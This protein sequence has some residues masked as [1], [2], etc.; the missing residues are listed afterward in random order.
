M[1]QEA[2][3]KI[4]KSIFPIFFHQKLN[5]GFRIGV[6]GTGFFIEGDLFVTA[7]HVINGLPKESKALYFGNV[8]DRPLKNPI[9][10]EEVYSDEVKDIFIG[11]VKAQSLDPLELSEAI[12]NA[13]KSICLSGYPLANL[14]KAPD[15]TINVGNVRPYWQP[16]FMVDR[17]TAN[18]ENRNY[19]GFMTQHTSL[20][21]MSGG[22]VFDT[23]GIVF[24]VDVATLTRKI[25]QTDG[26]EQLVPNG[27]VVGV[28]TLH[29]VLDTL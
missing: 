19:Q 27:V 21:G 6:S 13:G 7:D 15:G 4:R 5:N 10:I 25:P 12:P 28:E 17:I 23:E 22:P 11:R 9:E 16:T 3:S 1:Y 20:N 8:P 24:G 2:I 26:T 18:Q 14:S 29:E